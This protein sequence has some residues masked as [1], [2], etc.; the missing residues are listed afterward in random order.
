MSPK[1]GSERGEYT[2]REINLN[3]D[4]LIERRKDKFEGIIKMIKSAFRT[5]NESLR[6]QAIEE[7]KKEAD[8]DKEYSAMVKSVLA[9]EEILP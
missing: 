4:N 6:K 8:K 1:Q 7:L 9:S 5:S 2:Q 3:R